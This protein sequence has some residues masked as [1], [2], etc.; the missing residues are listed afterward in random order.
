MSIPSSLISTQDIVCSGSKDKQSIYTQVS[1][2]CAKL[3]GSPDHFIGRSDSESSVFAC[4]DHFIYQDRMIER[5][6]TSLFCLDTHYYHNGLQSVIFK[7]SPKYKDNTLIGTDFLGWKALSQSA[8][9]ELAIL[10]SM[11]IKSEKT[12]ALGEVSLILATEFDVLTPREFEI[13][14]LS[15]LGFKSKQIAYFYHLSHKTIDDYIYRAK[16][17]LQFNGHKKQLTE[18][19]VEEKQMHRTLPSSLLISH[20]A[21]KRLLS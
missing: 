7:R 5:L 17:K 1:E 9:T 11:K 13:L 10:L 18:F 8:I 20:K 14:Y 4:S 2:H 21:F 15:S 6:N 12:C 3:Y 16:S 19:L